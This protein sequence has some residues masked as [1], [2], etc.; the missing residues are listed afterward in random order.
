MLFTTKKKMDGNILTLCYGLT[1]VIS[2]QYFT[3]RRNQCLKELLPRIKSFFLPRIKSVTSNHKLIIT[4]VHGINSQYL[5]SIEF[6]AAG[7]NVKEILLRNNISNQKLV[8]QKK[9][10]TN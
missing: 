6:I 10:I 9:K 3:S 4:N 8:I 5:T 1:Y 7:I 2:L